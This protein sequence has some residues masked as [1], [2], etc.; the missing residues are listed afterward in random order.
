[1]S[2]VETAL[3]VGCS[4]RCWSLSLL[5]LAAA[6]GIGS[7]VGSHWMSRCCLKS[8]GPGTTWALL[9]LT[10]GFQH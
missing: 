4:G 5:A 10:E 8:S 6:P 2:V 9:G 7:A 3:Q 1:M